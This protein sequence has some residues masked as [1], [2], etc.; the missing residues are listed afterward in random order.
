MGLDF[1]VKLNFRITK[2]FHNIHHLIGVRNKVSKC[3]RSIHHSIRVYLDKQSILV[4]ESV[5]Q[6]SHIPRT[7]KISQ[8]IDQV[9]AVSFLANCRQNAY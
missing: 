3:E 4:A 9:N 1:C 6:H 5:N 8:G 2:C 7:V